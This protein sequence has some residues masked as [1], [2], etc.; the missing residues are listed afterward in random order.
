MYDLCV[1]WAG[2]K[3]FVCVI[4]CTLGWYGRFCMCD[5]CV[6]WAGTEGFVC[7]I[8]V[9]FGLV[10]KVLYVRFVCTL[11]WY[12]RFCMCDLFRGD[13]VRFKCKN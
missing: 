9:Y 13:T 5:V 6:L 3:G 1:L 11:G 4:V 7:V 10:R 8:C 12:G 2:T